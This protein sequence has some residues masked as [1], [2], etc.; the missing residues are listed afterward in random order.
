MKP[1]KVNMKKS[2]SPQ[3]NPR[4]K[5]K[6]DLNRTER[7]KMDGLE[8]HIPTLRDHDMDVEYKSGKVNSEGSVEW[9]EVIKDTFTE[10]N[11]R[12]YPQ[13][14]LEGII[15]DKSPN[16][17][18]C[19]ILRTEEGI[20]RIK[21]QYGNPILYL[22]ILKYSYVCDDLSFTKIATGKRKQK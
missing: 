17:H 1:T 13:W 3:T 21:N 12:E 22:Q 11:V 16:K 19:F 5:E 2:K 8:I 20:Y 14:N 4:V 18:F 6:K 15:I 10:E 9:S 7:V